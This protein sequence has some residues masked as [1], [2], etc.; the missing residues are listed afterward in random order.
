MQASA[1]ANAKTEYQRAKKQQQTD[2]DVSIE[3]KKTLHIQLDELECVLPVMF[4]RAQCTCR[5]RL[6]FRHG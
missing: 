1:A 4:L 6:S 2:N 3:H 5:R